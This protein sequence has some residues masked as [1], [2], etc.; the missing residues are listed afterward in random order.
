MGCSVFC[1][2]CAWPHVKSFWTA[3]NEAEGALYSTPFLFENISVVKCTATYADWSRRMIPFIPVN[4]LLLTYIRVFFRNY[5]NEPH[6]Q[7][8]VRRWHLV[9]QK[10]CIEKYWF[11]FT[12]TRTCSLLSFLFA[13]HSVVSR[14]HN[15]FLE[16]LQLFKTYSFGVAHV[17][18]PLKNTSNTSCR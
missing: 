16:N 3:S 11:R 7:H 8:C 10:V 17:W 2:D 13:S 9:C 5:G 12:M 4:L 1:K 6:L 14:V 15:Y 18:R